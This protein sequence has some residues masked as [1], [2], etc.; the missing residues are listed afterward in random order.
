MPKQYGPIQIT[1]TIDNVCFYKMDG[2]YFA[3]MKSSLTRKRVLKSTAFRRTREHAATLGE[4]SKIASRVYRLIPKAQRKHTLYRK[5]TG[6]A[7]YLLREGKNKEVIF[8]NLSALYLKQDKLPEPAVS[9]EK[10]EVQDDKGYSDEQQLLV[11]RLQKTCSGL[12]AGTPTRAINEAQDNRE[13]SCKREPPVPGLQ[14]TCSGLSARTP[15]RAINEAQDNREISC[16]REPPVPGLQKTYSGLLARTPTRAVNIVVKSNHLKHVSWVGFS[17]RGLKEGYRD[18][19]RLL[20]AT[21]RGRKRFSS[22]GLGKRDKA[23]GP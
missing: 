12:S 15:T 5:M 14:K 2:I 11:P 16:K 18:A 6:K 23:M 3:R 13:I 17:A 10:N 8:Q 9:C 20:P 4:A 19:Y 1:G 7:I 21:R 22:H